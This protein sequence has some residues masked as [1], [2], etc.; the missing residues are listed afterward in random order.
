MFQINFSS[1]TPIYEQLYTEVIRL[2]AAGA[3]KPGDKLPPVRIVA[4][5]LG[6]NPNTAAKAYRQLEA[7]GYIYSSVGRG[8]YLTDK[9]GEDSV[10]RQQATDAFFRAAKDAVKAG[11]TKGELQILLNDAFTE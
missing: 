6:I 5:N 7:N 3:L 2:A 10:Q 9:L 4:E 8:S 1:N 11:V